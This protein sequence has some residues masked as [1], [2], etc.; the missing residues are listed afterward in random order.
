MK[1][2]MQPRTSSRVSGKE[3]VREEPVYILLIKAL[4]CAYAVTG[5]LLVMLAFLL[6]KMDLNQQKVAVG[7]ILIYIIANF[8]G[9]FVSGRYMKEKKYLWGTILGLLYVV[10][11]FLI[12]FAVYR[13]MNQ[14]D[15]VTTMILC[16]VSGT[17]GGMLS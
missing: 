16:I 3:D 5:I 1:S 11:L 6:Y 2:R 10:L 9:G 4:L 14:G 12:T 8:C 7:I 17:I 13:T 15:V